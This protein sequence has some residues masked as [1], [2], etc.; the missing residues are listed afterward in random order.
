MENHRAAIFILVN[1][2]GSLD[3][4]QIVNITGMMIRNVHY[5]RETI[6]SNGKYPETL[7]NQG[8]SCAKPVRTAVV[9]QNL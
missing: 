1:N 2:W 6:M 4:P 7:M 5:L 9:M 8:W 3:T